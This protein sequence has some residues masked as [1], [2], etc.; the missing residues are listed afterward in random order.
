[1]KVTIVS[2]IFLFFLFGSDPIEGLHE[3]CLIEENRMPTPP[4]ITGDAFRAYADFI[5]DETTTS[6]NSEAIPD[7]SVIFVGPYVLKSFFEDHHPRIQGKYILITH[8]TDGEAPGP[9]AAFLDDEKIIAWFAQNVEKVVHP[10]LVPIPIGLGNR[11][12]YNVSLIDKMRK[13]NSGGSRDILLYMSFT[14]TGNDVPERKI[15]FELF[16]DKPYCKNYSR[17]IPYGEYLLNLQ[18]SKFGLSTR[19]WGLD[20]QRTWEILY[21]GA[22]PIV[23]S[24]ASD[25]M[26]EGLPVLIVNEWEEITEEFLIDAYEKISSKNGNLDKLN[27]DYW[28]KL[29]E[30]AKASDR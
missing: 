13:E 6:L 7:R 19:G 28:L 3:S 9:Y 10:K 23:K 11:Y 30:D 8:N 12:V 24:S 2:C 26:F 14:G 22:I 18:R 5:F 16:K 17:M 4:Y 25:E 1:M 20:C 21:M 27:I 15:V 29:I